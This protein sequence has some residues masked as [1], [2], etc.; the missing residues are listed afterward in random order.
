MFNEFFASCF[1]GVDSS[2]P[3]IPHIGLTPTVSPNSAS[4][5]SVSTS[6]VSPL[7]NTLECSGWD[8]LMAIKRLCCS[9]ASGPDDINATMLKRCTL[10]ITEPLAC[11]FN[12]SLCS[13]NVP[14][15]WKISHITPIY[16]KGDTSMVSNY[17]PISLLSLVS[18]LMERIVHSALLDHVLDV[19]FL[20]DCQFGFRPGS[21]IQEALLSLTDFWHKAMEEGLSNV[22]VFLD[23]AKAFDSLLLQC[24]AC[25]ISKQGWWPTS[26]LVC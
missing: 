18:K 11:I 1:T 16:K 24:R 13:S 14:T 5:D 6:P 4:A 17:C 20:S 7:L 26:V 23:V 12:T 15:E 9:T 19:G 3:Y 10:S 8:V 21:S 2:V 25:P 22:C